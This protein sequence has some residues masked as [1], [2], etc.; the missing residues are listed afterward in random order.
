M[1]VVL[2]EPVKSAAVVPSFERLQ[3]LYRA[4]RRLAVRSGELEA[5]NREFG[6]EKNFV[7]GGA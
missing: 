4:C 5:F 2:S 6:T 1:T 3:S 7:Y